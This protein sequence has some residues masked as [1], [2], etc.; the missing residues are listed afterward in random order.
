MMPDTAKNQSA[1][2]QNTQQ[3]LGVGFPI[4]SVTAIISLAT[5]CVLEAT[6]FIIDASGAA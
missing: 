5:G 1:Y 3:K 4:A 2:P 6:E